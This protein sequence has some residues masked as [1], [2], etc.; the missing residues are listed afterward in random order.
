[1]NAALAAPPDNAWNTVRLHFEA[2]NLSPY[3]TLA[4]VREEP[5]LFQGGR[6]V[7]IDFLRNVAEAHRD[8]ARELGLE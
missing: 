2:C 8:T 1:M 3:D 4:D 5:A 7:S 6:E